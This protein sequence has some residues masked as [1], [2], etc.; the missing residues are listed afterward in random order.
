M[1]ER[2]GLLLLGYQVAIYTLEQG[3][4]IAEDAARNAALRMDAEANIEQARMASAY[5]MAIDLLRE[6]LQRM[7][8]FQRSVAGGHDGQQT[9]SGAMQGGAG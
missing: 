1:S 3:L 4:K 7:Q 8:E 6:Q 5:R 2:K 9:N